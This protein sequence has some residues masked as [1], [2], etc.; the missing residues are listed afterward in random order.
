[1]NQQHEKLMTDLHRILATQ[2][3]KSEKEMNDFLNKLMEK[4]IP[5]FP[6]EALSFE[7]QAQDLVFE[8]DGLSTVKGR[9]KIIEALDLNPN[10]IEAYEYLGQKEPVIEIAI[11][12]FNMGVTIGR[13]LW[14]KEYLEENNGMFWGLHETRPFMRCLQSYADSL[15]SLGKIEECVAIMEEM[16]ELNPND[17][18]CIRNVLM[19]NLIKLDENE[20]FE[21]Y[22]KMFEG[23]ES[24]FYLFNLA[25]N[26][27]KTKG[28]GMD[29]N[30]KLSMALKQNK[31]VAAKLLSTK[32]NDV[33]PST[34]GSGDVNEANYYTLFSQFIWKD[35]DGALAWLKKYNVK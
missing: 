14:C 18:Q 11:A 31:F 24:A 8:A 21:K 2:D 7:E 3:F 28:E 22:A 33:F 15:N 5:S 20:K 30:R 26:A 35:T 10:C 32:L 9:K 29:A 4:E 27:F 17:N 23:E 12:F 1:M 19:L 25:L 34:Y 13:E 6:N 16:I